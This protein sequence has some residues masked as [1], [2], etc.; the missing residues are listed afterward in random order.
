MKVLSSKTVYS[1]KYFRIQQEQIER[2]GRTFTKDFIERNAVTIIIPY[3][4]DNEIYMESQF[5]DALG[6]RSLEIVAGHVEEGE[7]PLETAKK[8]L[9]EEAGLTAKTWHTLGLWDLNINMRAKVHVYAATDL[10]EG[11]TALEEDEDI[12]IVK[13]PLDEVIKKV[14]E[15]KV[16]AASHIA[17]LLLFKKMR[18]EGKL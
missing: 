5:R 2:D 7:E 17:A 6:E 9:K 8:E 1:S 10:T 11:E 16:R 4:A 3:T 14:E 18:E 12:T 13:M 15:G